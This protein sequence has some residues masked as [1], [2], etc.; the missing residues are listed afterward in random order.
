MN[1]VDILLGMDRAEFE[2]VN[3]KSLEIKRLS[4]KAKQPFM[5]KIGAIPARRLT[6]FLSGTTDK[7]GQVQMDKAYDAN[8]NICLAG[9]ID[10]SMKEKKLM[11]GLGCNTPGETLE[12]IFQ[13]NEINMI[14]DAI[15]ELSGFAGN[16]V[17]EEVKN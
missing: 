1:T 8:V 11:D 2:N 9:L 14:A 5:V 10:P 7:S 4:K 12:K 6:K 3:E 13:P 15:M 16:D 17:V